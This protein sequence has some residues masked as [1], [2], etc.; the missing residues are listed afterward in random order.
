[1]KIIAAITPGN[2]PHSVR[3]DTKS[4]APHPLSNTDK[5]GNINDMIALKTPIFKMLSCHHH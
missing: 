2:H 4:M 1:M 3:I 5:G